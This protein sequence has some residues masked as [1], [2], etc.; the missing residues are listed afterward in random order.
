MKNETGIILT[1][2]DF[3][4]L[5]AMR[6]LVN[7]NIPVVILDHEHCI[8]RYSRYK[9]R[10]IQSPSL[11]NHAAYVQFLIELADKEQL[12]DWII[13]PNSDEAVYLL[14][15]FRHLLQPYYRT[16]VQNWSVI[17][18]VY[19][20][21]NTYQLAEQL[22]IAIPKSWFPA[23]EEELRKLDLPFPVIIKP[24]IRDHLYKKVHVKAY[25]ADTMKE[26]VTVYRN[27]CRLIDPSE[28]VV[29]DMIPG[30]ADVLY[31]FCPFFK[32]GKVRASIT[33]KRSRQHPMTFGHATT[34]AELVSI[35]ELEGYATTFLSAIGYYG[36]CEVEFMYD[37]RDGRYKFLEINP[38]IWGWHSLA[39]AAGVNF[40]CML[41]DDMMGILREP[42]L[43][44]DHLKWV[45]LTT[46]I[47]TVFGEIIK[48]RMKLRDY[49]ASMKGNKTFAVFSAKDPLPF[50][51]E[52]IMLPYLAIKRGF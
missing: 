7:R 16:P 48:G 40:P 37:R 6:A 24:S 46:D 2:G 4:G 11:S 12:R 52:L 13:I 26:L 10:Q 41:Y 45:R 23:N 49:L 22:N 3:Q 43:P 33:A 32:D 39:I 27:V 1:G 20:K 21:K 51:A 47:P 18:N 14:C 38:R 31:S 8:S 34:F 50:F 28:V 15:T 42:C 44:V 29:Q 17:E 25:R 36:V 5:A 30:G 19:V 35:P 9:H